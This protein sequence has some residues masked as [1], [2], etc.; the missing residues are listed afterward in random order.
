MTSYT[1]TASPGGARV[2]VSER[3][4]ARVGYAIVPGLASG[5]AYTF[6]VTARNA[7][8]SSAPSL[9][10]G[11]VTPR[12]S[13]GSAPGAPTGFTAYADGSNVSLHWDPPAS[14]GG[15]PVIGYTISAPGLRPVTV[16]GHTVNWATSSRNIFTTLG[17]LTA[18]TP[19]TFQITADNV[20]G[21][22]AAADTTIVSG[23]NPAC[24]G[25]ALA[26]SPAASSSQ[27]G[28]TLQVT[29]TLTNG[30]AVALSGA[31]LYLTASNGYQVG[32]ASPVSAGNIAAGGSAT[33]TWSVTVPA[34]ATAGAQL[35]ATAVFTE[36]G[37]EQAAQASG[38]V[39]IPAPSLET[40]FDNVGITD[41]S[42]TTIG[43]LDGAGSSFSAQAL[44]A[45]G[46]T[47]GGTVTAGGASFTWPGVASGDNDN[48][49]ASGQS[50]DLSGSGS[51][52]SFL[53]TAGYGPAS[54]TGQ[55]VYADGS[56]QSFTLSVPDWH[57]SCAATGAGVALYMPYRNR[58]SGQNSLPVC[59]YD[60][61]VPLQAGQPVARIVLPDVS[62]GVT[63]GSPSLHIFA[64][65]I[66]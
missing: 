9:P 48:V 36:A 23:V 1:V 7:L 16:T 46:A 2:T 26:V 66:S 45:A 14:E 39:S 58:A 18:G 42:D 65:T 61:S 10:A 6:T 5:T 32:P 60:T 49:V 25:A 41:D 17:G 56:T 54:G 29:T 8:G 59:V 34:G 62:G 12:A 21:P 11:P 52:L 22:G 20:T 38:T 24:A 44:A 15:T 3:E 63:S 40:A 51:T 35:F 55:V 30:C 47:P 64:V 19:Y 50:F 37:Q 27:P 28:S 53:L 4:F 43:N 13:L 57:G 31:R 33:Q